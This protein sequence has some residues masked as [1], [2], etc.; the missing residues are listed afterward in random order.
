LLPRARG[1]IQE[2]EEMKRLVS[3]LSGE[4][5]GRLSLGTS[6]HIGLHRLPPILKRFIHLYPQVVLDIHFMDSEAACRA[7][8][9]GELELA[10]VTLPDEPPDHLKTTTIWIDRLLFISSHDHPLADKRG[11]TLRQLVA[12]P[13]VLPGPATY[14]RSILNRAMA[15]EG[16]SLNTALSTNYLE[17]LKMLASTGLGW[18]LLPHTMLSGDLVAL[19]VS[20]MNL[21]RHLGLVAHRHRT[22]SN[23]AQRL[24]QLC[25]EV[26]EHPV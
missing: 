21:S 23:A 19:D 4:V 9:T 18:S 20:D 17:T 24:N 25:R 13:A 16:L 1:L 12:Y 14:T 26:S 11:I 15:L 22:P 7:V 6:H 2:V 5:G 3:H 8:E 10:I